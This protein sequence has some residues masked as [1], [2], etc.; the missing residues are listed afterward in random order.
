MKRA[1]VTIRKRKDLGSIKG[2]YSGDRVIFTVNGDEFEYECIGRFFG[3]K[4]GGND[5]IF[6]ML[7]LNKEE[8]CKR[9]YGEFSSKG[10]WPECR[11]SNEDEHAKKMWQV[12][13][14]LYI[15]LEKQGHM[16]KT[17][18]TISS[19]EEL[20]KFKGKMCEGMTIVVNGTE[21][22]IEKNFFIFVGDRHH[23]GSFDKLAKE[24]C[25]T[26]DD[27]CRSYYGTEECSGE[28]SI[29]PEFNYEDY[30]AAWRCAMMLFTQAEIVSSRKSALVSEKSIIED[31][32]WAIKEMQ[33]AREENDKKREELEAQIRKLHSDNE[34]YAREIRQLKRTIFQSQS[35]LKE[36]K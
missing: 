20:V 19:I 5:A 8:F 9:S 17:P 28:T 21:L 6:R 25:I 34:L 14:D 2:I 32:E 30:E 29:W 16:V 23:K 10:T 1:R 15:E 26:K 24:L 31:A 12:I 22:Q 11:F 27:I 35:A 4:Y 18:D 7:G 33:K 36:S 3:Y 13:N